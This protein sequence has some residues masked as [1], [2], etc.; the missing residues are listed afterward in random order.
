M[1]GLNSFSRVTHFFTHNSQTHIFLFL[2]L[3][4]RAGKYLNLFLRG[5]G[6][7]VLNLGSVLF[8]IITTITNKQNYAFLPLFLLDFPST[9]ISVVIKWIHIWL[10]QL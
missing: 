8:T 10:A 1:I 6:H 2:F 5:R 3:M 7:A 9:A 4:Q